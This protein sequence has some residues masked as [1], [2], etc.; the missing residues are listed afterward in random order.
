M[1]EYLRAIL[2]FPQINQTNVNL[3][4]YDG[5]YGLPAYGHWGKNKNGRH[6]FVNMT[7]LG[8][9]HNWQT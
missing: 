2:F 4:T 9:E 6:N 7:D 1:V 5:L 8:K 3:G